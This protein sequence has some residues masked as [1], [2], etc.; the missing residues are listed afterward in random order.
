M[1]FQGINLTAIMFTFVVHVRRRPDVSL[2]AYL[3]FPPTLPDG[4]WWGG[5]L[6]LCNTGCQRRCQVRVFKRFVLINHLISRCVFSVPYMWSY[7]EIMSATNKSFFKMCTIAIINYSLLFLPQHAN[8]CTV[9][10]CTSLEKTWKWFFISYN[11][12]V[13]E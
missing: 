7:G 12:C 4:C 11:Y 10:Y 3:H 5:A 9:T 1:V 13:I 2:R 8:W 6:S